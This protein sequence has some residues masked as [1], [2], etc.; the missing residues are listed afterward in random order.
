MWPGVENRDRL[1]YLFIICAAGLGVLLSKRIHGSRKDIFTGH[2]KI[3]YLLTFIGISL[4]FFELNASDTRLGDVGYFTAFKFFDLF[5]LGTVLL[6][7]VLRSPNPLSSDLLR[8]LSLTIG[9]VVGIVR[10]T[11]L[12]RIESGVLDAYHASSVAN[13]VLAVRA[14]SFPLFDFVA[15]Y[16]SG[17][18]YFF[19]AF[20]WLSPMGTITN[21]FAFVSALNFAVVITV[22]LS[23]R[24]AWR[25]WPAAVWPSYWLSPV[26]LFQT[27]GTISKLLH[28]P[29]RTGLMCLLGPPGLLL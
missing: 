12:V 25:S 17:L 24:W 9:T 10:L 8:K 2:N 26:L 6:V 15:Q 11:S 20:N 21:L 29:T 22:V 1:V 16:T 5:I 19:A 13:E 23:I 4:L 27:E 7:W 14:G 18:G 3:T 28:Q